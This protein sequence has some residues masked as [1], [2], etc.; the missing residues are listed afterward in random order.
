ML[1]RT[2]AIMQKLVGRVGEREGEWEGGEEGEGEGGKGRVR[3]GV[4]DV[5]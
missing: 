4:R 5:G 3:G 1:K 2:F